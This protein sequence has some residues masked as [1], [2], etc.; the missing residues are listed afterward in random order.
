MLVLGWKTVQWTDHNISL[1][2]VL[3]IKHHKNIFN[4]VLMSLKLLLLSYMLWY[5]EILGRVHNK[6]NNIATISYVLYF[7]IGK[8]KSQVALKCSQ[9]IEQHK[10]SK[11]KPDFSFKIG[12]IFDNINA[13]DKTCRDFE[14]FRSLCSGNT[15]QHLRLQ[16]FAKLATMNYLGKSFKGSNGWPWKDRC[17]TR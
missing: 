10:R 9:L 12:R 11:G 15:W 5:L 7:S 14:W 2:N 17:M 16:Y 1:W 6:T 4:L 13:T 8:P 3:E